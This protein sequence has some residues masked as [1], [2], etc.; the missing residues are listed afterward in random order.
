M[1]HTP[2]DGQRISVWMAEISGRAFPIKLKAETEIGENGK[3]HMV[4]LMWA[5]RMSRPAGRRLSLWASY[6]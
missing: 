4:I 1:P 2:E 6:A 3:T 5:T